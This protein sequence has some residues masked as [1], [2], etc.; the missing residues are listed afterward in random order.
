MDEK[1]PQEN[2]KTKTWKRVK[3]FDSYEEAITLKTKLLCEGDPALE[4]KIRRF[5]NGGNQFQ[6]KTYSP[7]PTKKKSKKKR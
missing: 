1:Q 4:V 5:G 7:A 3:V 2:Q 6:V